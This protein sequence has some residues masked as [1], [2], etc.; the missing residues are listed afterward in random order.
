MHA[1]LNANLPAVGLQD[2]FKVPYDRPCM[3]EF[4][5]RG[6]IAA[7]PVRS[8]DISKRPID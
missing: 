3:H 7:S 8:L 4:V 6:H 2:C 1:V 5:C